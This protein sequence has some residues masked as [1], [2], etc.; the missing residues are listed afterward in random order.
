MR[1]AKDL[2]AMRAGAARVA[3]KKI[4]RSVKCARLYAQQK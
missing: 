2:C 1:G 3:Q 4:K